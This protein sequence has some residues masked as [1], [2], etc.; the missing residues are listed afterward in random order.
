[1]NT[2]QNNLLR[3]AADP[4]T[5]LSRLRELSRLKGK[6][7]RQHLRTLIAANPS[8]DEKLLWDLAHD[9]DEQVYAN[10]LFKRL[11]LA[12]VSWWEQCGTTALMRLLARMGAEAPERAR[13][14]LLEQVADELVHL[15]PSYRGEMKWIWEEEIKIAWNAA[16]GDSKN[17][18]LRRPN[19]CI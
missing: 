18:E 16:S 8:I 19:E 2:K 5:S 11:L 14:H 6:N 12:N 17:G 9:C 13:N 3:E 15:N 7:V 1:M 10:P 4:S